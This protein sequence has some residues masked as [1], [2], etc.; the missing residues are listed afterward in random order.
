MQDT[1]IFGS[2]TTGLLAYGSAPL[3]IAQDLAEREIEPLKA[4]LAMQEIQGH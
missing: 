1:D 4:E 3:L 2:V